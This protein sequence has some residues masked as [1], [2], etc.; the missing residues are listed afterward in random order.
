M[1]TK[2]ISHIQFTKEGYEEI[3]SRL[4][5]LLEKR[6]R[7]LIDLQTAR[8]MGD[9]SENGA[10]KAARWELG[11]IDR[12]IR[13]LIY[14]KRFGRVA[15]SETKK[16]IVGFGTKVTILS[17]DAKMVFTMVEGYEADPGK[18]KLSL[19]SPLGKAILG[20]KENDKAI[21]HTPSGEK[22]LQIIS[23]D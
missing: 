17:G 3:I 11:G 16:K 4:N 23:I 22:T 19:Y 1:N 18:N 9:L 12:Q 5:K 14:L 10:Y 2:R 8:E 7:V 20:K 15:N 21:F 6:K 13:H